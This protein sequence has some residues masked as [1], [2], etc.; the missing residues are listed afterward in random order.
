MPDFKTKKLRKHYQSL[1]SEREQIESVWRELADNFLPLKRKLLDEDHKPEDV[2]NFMGKANNFILDSTPIKATRVLG[3]GLQSGMT[4]PAKRWFKLGLHNREAEELAAVKKWLSDAQD[5][6]FS[7]MSISN[8]YNNTHRCYLEVAIFGILVMLI[9][10]DDEKNIRTICLPA[11]SYVLSSNFK[12]IP[13]TLYRQIFMT[14]EQMSDQFGEE[15][16]SFSVKN[17]LQNEAT[18]NNWF[19]VIHAI[20]PNDDADST[21]ED[22]QSMAYSSVY[23]EENTTE[24]DEKGVLKEGGFREKPF[25]AA[26]WDVTGESVY[27]D[28]PAMDILPFAK[29]LQSMTTTLLKTKQKNADPALNVPSSLKNTPVSTA[30]GVLNYLANPNEKIEPTVTIRGETA[31]TQQSI[32]DVRQQILAGL[33][34]DIFRALA[35]SP[36][37]K[38]TATEVLE[39]KSEGLRLLGPVLERLQFE[40]LDPIIDRIFSISLRLGLFPPVP[41]E[42]EGTE[43]KVEYISP[44]AQAQRAVGAEAFNQLLGFIQA[45]ATLNPLVLDKI[46]FDQMADLYAALIGV[47]PEVMND[48]ETVERIRELRRLRQQEALEQEKQRQDAEDLKTMSETQVTSNANAIEAAAAATEAA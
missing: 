6:I 5:S 27:G 18:K 13:D 46:D 29:Q 9:L 45:M 38:M 32:L 40:L 10:E 30:P 43:L 33:F 4:S 41:A 12:G 19:S 2:Y 11:G 17:A 26:R 35:L 20:F 3:A 23:F 44:L 22:F 15:N 39:R 24:N 16:L 48:D 37:D 47:S 42:L 7:V 21:K 34:N 25:V 14:A 28:S 31:D 36:S 1:L 8:F